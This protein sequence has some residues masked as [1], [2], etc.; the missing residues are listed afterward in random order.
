MLFIAMLILFY[1]FIFG[2]F[3]NA[4]LCYFS[5]ETFSPQCPSVFLNKLS[6]I[7]KLR[8]ITC[9]SVQHILQL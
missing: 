7:K 4:F 8:T 9:H 5:E 3:L 2:L 6:P 1:F